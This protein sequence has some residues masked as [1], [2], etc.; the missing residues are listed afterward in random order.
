MS[1]YYFKLAEKDL[2]QLQNLNLITQIQ[3]E[4][5]INQSKKRIPG[6]FD[7]NPLYI[8]LNK[9]E[10]IRLSSIHFYG[11]EHFNEPYYFLAEMQSFT[12]NSHMSRFFNRYGLKYPIHT[13]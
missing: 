5:L 1:K 10:T 7:K 8:W 9:S 2:N 6:Q 12:T 13:Y 4:Q 11:G 3:K